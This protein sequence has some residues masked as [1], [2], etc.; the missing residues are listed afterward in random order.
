[1]RQALVCI[2]MAA[3]TSFAWAEEPLDAQDAL[4]ALVQA[5][6]D[7]DLLAEQE[8]A[9]KVLESVDFTGEL[10]GVVR[11]MKALDPKRS[12]AF[13]SAHLLAGEIL[14]RS[15]ASGEFKLV[16]D[17]SEVLALH[18]KSKNIGK[19]AGALEMYG[20]AMSSI[21]ADKHKAAL[22]PLGKVLE[23][24]EDE[25]W[26][27]LAIHAGTE[28]CAAA[29]ELGDEKK[30]RKFMSQVAKSLGT[31]ASTSE[32]KTWR[33]LAKARLG[34]ASESVMAPMEEYMKQ[35]RGGA[36]G[37][38]G[39][40]GVPGGDRAPSLLARA[41]EAPKLKKPLAIV[42]RQKDEFTIQLGFNKSKKG[43][44]EFGKL[45]AH[46]ELGGVVLSFH[47]RAV[48]LQRLELQQDPSLPA[49]AARRGPGRAWYLLAEKESWELQPDGS[50]AIR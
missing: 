13:L 17:A 25:G 46:Q 36:P 3:L 23:L 39:G 34:K 49:G 2:A 19:H 45:V 37:G 4:E 26:F 40:R 41:L 1:M 31:E 9:Q 10:E 16:A 22:G 29:L 6:L 28:A 50:I 8:A 32:S 42:K 38:A 12:G 43:A 7:K 44:Q 30:A 18:A 14:K 24:C 5:Q 33:V 15:T 21:D 27:D 11:V 20:E 47:H 35:D 48:A